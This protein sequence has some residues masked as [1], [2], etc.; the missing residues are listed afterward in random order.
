MSETDSNRTRIYLDY[1][2]ATPLTPLVWEAMLPYLTTHYGNASALHAEGRTARAAVEEARTKTARVLGG[3]TEQLYFTASGTESNNLAILGYLQMLHNNGRSYEA[4]EVLLTEIE[5]PSLLSLVPILKKRGVSVG[6]VPVDERGFI[7]RSELDKLISERTVLV[8]FSYINSEIGTI[9]PVSTL[10]RI[11]RNQESVLGTKIQV[12]LDAAQA[13]LWNSCYLPQLGVDTMT[14]D[15][16]KCGGPKGV[17]VLFARL[18]AALAPI[19]FGGGQER[20]LRPGTENVAGIVG[21]GVAIFE[22]QKKYQARQEPVMK[23]RDQ[24]LVELANILPTAV[25]NGATGE[26]RVANNINFSLPG[27]DTEYAVVWL[28]KCG[29]AASTKSACA[30]AG[31]GISGVVL[32]CTKNVDLAKSTIR[33]TLGE[34]SNVE[35]L[36][37]V[38]AELARLNA[39]MQS[40]T[41]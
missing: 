40:L 28:D 39:Q 5:H 41:K 26:T 10:V 8:A 3:R 23:V 2:A 37:Y 18:P 30:G 16:G 25:L 4:M 11:I 36:K 14:L 15:A 21:A 29:V 31:G 20:G 6:L 17:G 27:M 38:F 32:A 13:P 33:L 19:N 12:H 34:H 7:V 9:Q 22:A 24:G 35:E 1:A